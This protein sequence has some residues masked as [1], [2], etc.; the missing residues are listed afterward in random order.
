MKPE[1]GKLPEHIEKLFEEA[2]NVTKNS[3]NYWRLRCTY[4]EKMEDMTYSQQER[5]NCY[6]LWATLLN[7]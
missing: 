1:E 5:D 6:N 7:R 4:R 3:V 2:K